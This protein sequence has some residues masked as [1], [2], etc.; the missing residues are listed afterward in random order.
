MLEQV[1]KKCRRC[2]LLKKTL[3]FLCP[4]PLH[5]KS[6]T[7]TTTPLA[8]FTVSRKA[9]LFYP[10]CVIFPGWNDLNV[11]GPDQLVT[12]R[13]T[14]TCPRPV[15]DCRSD[16]TERTVLGKGKTPERRIKKKIQGSQSSK[17]Q[18]V[19]LCKKFLYKELM[20][21]NFAQIFENISLLIDNIYCI[22]L[23]NSVSY[24]VLFCCLKIVFVKTCLATPFHP[25]YIHV[26]RKLFTIAIK[27]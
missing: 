24:K 23:C 3:T 20:W 16:D 8:M 1:F 17:L 22:I 25:L 13:V 19:K 18:H 21:I 11:H 5:Y 7:L 2:F 12:D 10:V 4:Q 26:S 15:T 27:L 6:R 14:S 9:T